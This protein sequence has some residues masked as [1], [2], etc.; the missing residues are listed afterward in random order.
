[1]H[2]KYILNFS[3]A[4]TSDCFAAA[5]GGQKMAIPF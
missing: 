5:Q 1:M 4:T 3:D 2:V